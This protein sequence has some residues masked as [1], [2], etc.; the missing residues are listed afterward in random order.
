MSLMSWVPQMEGGPAKSL[1]A[2]GASKPHQEPLNLYVHPEP[3]PDLDERLLRDTAAPSLQAAKTTDG[4]A[5]S[6]DSQPSGSLELRKDYNYEAQPCLASSPSAVQRDQ[7]VFTL[8]TAGRSSDSYDGQHSSLMGCSDSHSLHLGA[9]NTS[10]DQERSA[11]C[12]VD[13]RQRVPSD[14]TA[15]AVV[16]AQQQIQILDQHQQQN[17]PQ[18]QIKQEQQQEQP[19]SSERPWP[20]SALHQ[21]L[22]S[23]SAAPLPPFEPMQADCS[24]YKSPSTCPAREAP[25]GGGELVSVHSLSLSGPDR[26]LLDQLL[27]SEPGASS[28]PLVTPSSFLAAGPFGDASLQP[29]FSDYS[30]RPTPAQGPGDQLEAEADS[31]V[32]VPVQRNAK[33]GGFGNAGGAQP[34]PRSQPL[35]S[36]YSEPAP[37]SALPSRH[38]A[39]ALHPRPSCP[40]AGAQPAGGRPAAGGPPSGSAAAAQEDVGGAQY[41][42][43]QQ[44]H[45]GAGAE[46]SGLQ[47]WPGRPS[48]GRS[49]YESAEQAPPPQQEQQQQQQMQQQQQFQQMHA[50][51]QQQQ[52]QVSQQRARSATH[53]NVP[54]CT[55]QHM[56]VLDEHGLLAP[57][58]SAPVQG[59]SSAR[60]TTQLLKPASRASSG[61]AASPMHVDAPSR[62]HGYA[63]FASGVAAGA[64]ANAGSAMDVGAGPPPQSTAACANPTNSTGGSYPAPMQSSPSDSRGKRLRPHTGEGRP[65]TTSAPAGP[66][67]ALPLPTHAGAPPPQPTASAG[68]GSAPAAARANSP[69]SRSQSAGDPMSVSGMEG[70]AMYGQGPG[71][72]YPYSM[73]PPYSMPYSMPYGDPYYHPG[74][75]YHPMMDAPP[76][77]PAGPDAIAA[78][79]GGP[80]HNTQLHYPHG[81]VAP[82]QRLYRRFVSGGQQGR[83]D[84]TGQ[85]LDALPAAGQG[86]EGLMP[87]GSGPGGSTGAAPPPAMHAGGPPARPQPAPSSAAAAGAGPMQGFHPGPRPGGASSCGGSGAAAAGAVAMDMQYAGPA[88][89]ASA[90]G[91]AQG[92]MMQMQMPAGPPR[93]APGGPPTLPGAE[94]DVESFRAARACHEQFASDDMPL[95]LPRSTVDG[96]RQELRV[97]TQEFLQRRMDL[98]RSKQLQAAAAAAAAAN[99]DGGQARLQPSS[100]WAAGDTR[101]TLSVPTAPATAPFSHQ[102]NPHQYHHPQHSGMPPSYSADGFSHGMALAYP[103][104]AGAGGGSGGQ[105]TTASLPHKRGASAGLSA[106]G[107]A[108]SPVR[109]RPAPSAPTAAHSAPLASVRAAAASGLRR[110]AEGFPCD[111]GPAM[112]RPAMS[113]KSSASATHSVS[114]AQTAPLRG[115]VQQQQQQLQHQQQQQQQKGPG[116]MAMGSYRVGQQGSMAAEVED[117]GEEVH[118]PPQRSSANRSV[119]PPAAVSSN[120]CGPPSSMPMPPSYY[121]GAVPPP[122]YDYPSGYYYPPTM[123]TYGMRMYGM[124]PPPSMPPGYRPPASSAVPMYGMPPP[125]MPYTGSGAVPSPWPEYGAPPMPGGP[126]PQSGPG[127]PMTHG[128]SSGGMPSAMHI[129][130]GAPAGGGSTSEYMQSAAGR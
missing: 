14:A 83:R 66:A 70:A 81:Y 85:S 55:S 119:G 116:L 16:A 32:Q 47:R 97:V 84:G 87:M 12:N 91:A 29:A 9:G 5:R 15:A 3:S 38:M 120:A 127:A 98:A 103:S 36:A 123:P 59:Q 74:Y 82:R 21:N 58:H 101:S 13:F 129:R 92:Q 28:P 68:G 42:Q 106:G 40:L 121:G 61:G 111:T 67:P 115:A 35:S 33:S 2:E 24:G 49:G 99:G 69:S 10:M 6:L 88:D 76:P 105:S 94:M 45:K 53:V 112:A 20:Q 80:P 34:Q 30:Q 65:A 56:S 52:Q 17:L 4:T 63:P 108:V 57:A 71:Y 86:Q 62:P 96:I 93:A 1:T 44:G 100:S 26:D 18:E 39:P 72:P 25:A 11:E 27:G 60:Q 8:S 23:D 48:D 104:S 41:Q 113:G 122:P 95:P 7:R 128:S 107:G 75:G 124:P 109:A 125:P 46:D 102:Y 43:Q 37:Y 31:A 22:D 50:Q 54:Y 110:S 90:G 51:Q 19:R 114:V 64:A 77:P 78:G 73:P 130:G 89:Q 118:G 117:D 126:M 79:Y